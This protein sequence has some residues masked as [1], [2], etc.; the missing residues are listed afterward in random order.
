M[1]GNDI[2][3]GQLHKEMLWGG[4]ESA[5]V[6]NADPEEYAG[7]YSFVRWTEKGV[8]HGTISFYYFE[9]D[10]RL[11]VYSAGLRSWKESSHEKNVGLGSNFSNMPK[12]KEE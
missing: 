6:Q 8:T 11:G 7:N 5:R 10:G 3:F 9:P 12:P 1:I 2:F 4:S